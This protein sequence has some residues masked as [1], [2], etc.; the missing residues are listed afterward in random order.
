MAGA[1]KQSLCRMLLRQS[2]CVDMSATVKCCRTLES[3]TPMGSL[4][5]AL[6]RLLSRKRVPLCQP[7]RAHPAATAGIR[8]GSAKNEAAKAIELTQTMPQK[9]DL[10]DPWGNCHPVKDA[11]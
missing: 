1:T 3:L 9:G 2:S 11:K 5:H 7:A 8:N 10:T 4:G 6:Q